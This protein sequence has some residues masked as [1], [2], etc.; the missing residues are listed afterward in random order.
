MDAATKLK[1]DA[2]AMVEC[3]PRGFSCP[4]TVEG[5]TTT[6]NF[7][8]N[9]TGRPVPLN[10]KFRAMVDGMNSD[11]YLQPVDAWLRNSHIVAKGELARGAGGQGHEI[12]LDVNMA[13]ELLGPSNTLKSPAETPSS[14]CLRAVRLPPVELLTARILHPAGIRVD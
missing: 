8:F 10:T 9:L 2:N 3:S 4:R 14:C 11:T 12:H 7:R 13:P 1:A 5:E 6:P